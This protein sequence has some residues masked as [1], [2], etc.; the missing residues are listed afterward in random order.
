MF[1]GLLFS[2]QQ[3]ADV[4]VPASDLNPAGHCVHAG[5]EAFENVSAGHVEHDVAA[6]AD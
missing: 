3:S 2:P 1:C 5:A 4:V 6:S